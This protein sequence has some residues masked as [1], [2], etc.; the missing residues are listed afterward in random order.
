MK[1]GIALPQIGTWAI[2]ENIVKV[3]QRA[4]EIGYNSLWVLERLLWPLK[5]RSL[6]HATPDGSLP[7]S[8]Q[9]AFDPIVTLTYAAA[10]TQRIRLGTSVLVMPFHT[11]VVLA[12]QLATLDIISG[13]RLDCGLGLGWSEDEFEATNA[14]F[15]NLDDRG[16]EFLR[17]LKVLWTE[18]EPEFHG[19][20]YHVPKSKINPKPIQKPHPPLTIGGY[21]PRAFKRAVTLADGYN[22]AALP[23]DQMREL[24]ARF[25]QA[26]QAAGRNLSE[27]QF[28]WRWIPKLLDQSLGTNRQP[29]IGTVQKIRDDLRRCEEI[30]VTESFFDLNFETGIT[31]DELFHVME[32]LHP[33]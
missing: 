21:N 32:Q 1:L 30:G 26:A 8:Y 7:E 12:K 16:D 14:T 5:P 11:P 31:V 23:F 10:N 20:F 3:A 33:A 17:C 24:L 2:P 19:R 13:G 6:Y 9:C 28:V 29:F 15:K 22:G 4:E 25:K 27:L 18:E